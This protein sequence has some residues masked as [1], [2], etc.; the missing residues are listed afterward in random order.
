MRYRGG[1][2][3]VISTYVAVLI[4]TI[5]GGGLTLIIVRAIAQ[6]DFSSITALAAS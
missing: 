3:R 4:I 5:F 2:D 6:I 1:R